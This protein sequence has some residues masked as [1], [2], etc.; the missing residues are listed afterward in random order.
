MN[1]NKTRKK[2]ENGPVRCPKG[3]KWVASLNKCLPK[4]EA[5]NI[6]QQ[7]KQKKTRKKKK[8]F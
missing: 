3:Q 6:L 7:E 1:T 2:R 8:L 4:A 5:E